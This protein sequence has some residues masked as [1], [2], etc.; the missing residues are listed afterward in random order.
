[1]AAPNNI[2]FDPGLL[3]LHYAISGSP[4]WKEV[5]EA[6]TRLQRLQ[7]SGASPYDEMELDRDK[8]LQF[9][10]LLLTSADRIAYAVCLAAHLARFSNTKAFEQRL[11]EGFQALSTGLGLNLLRETEI[12]DELQRCVRA[13]FPDLKLEFPPLSAPA[14]A[15]PAATTSAQSSAAA[16]QSPAEPVPHSGA[17][18]SAIVKEAPTADAPPKSAEAPAPVP[19][20]PTGSREGPSPARET[21]KSAEPQTGPPD[22]LIPPAELLPTPSQSAEPQKAGPQTPSPSADSQPS[23]PKLR[24]RLPSLQSRRRIR[25]GSRSS[26]CWPKSRSWILWA[27]RKLKCEHPMS[28]RADF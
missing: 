7:G 9:E 24:P 23:A 28:G 4:S 17:A 16:T 26:W 18:A 2:L 8:T 22:T 11:I 3:Q 5:N 19:P 14:A 13:A 21:A 20:A 12:R 15:A 25:G 1:M 6:L 10:K 27:S